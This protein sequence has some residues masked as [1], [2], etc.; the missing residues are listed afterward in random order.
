LFLITIPRTSKSQE[1]FR[2]TGLCHISIKERHIDYKVG[3]HSVTTANSSV[4][5][6]PIASNHLAVCGAGVATCTKNARKKGRLPLF[7]A[8][9]TVSCGRVENHTLP[10]IGAAATRKKELQKKK[11][12]RTPNTTTG[13]MF[14]SNITTPGLSFA[15]ALRGGTAQQ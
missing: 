8:A 12:Q 3:S 13:R 5:C 11:T 1:I 4:T 15:A 9:A 7:Q 6:G 2:L 14:S 10:T